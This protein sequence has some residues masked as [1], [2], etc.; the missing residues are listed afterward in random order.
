MYV[1]TYVY[2]YIYTHIFVIVRGF[3]ARLAVPAASEARRR[4]LPRCSVPRLVEADVPWGL[5]VSRI[6]S[7][8]NS[9]SSTDKI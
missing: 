7:L 4:T 5:A 8:L 1:Y 3:P 6:S 9:A 2:I